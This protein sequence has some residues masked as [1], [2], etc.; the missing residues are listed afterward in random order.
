MFHKK[1]YLIDCIKTALEK[2]YR[3]NQNEKTYLDLTIKTLEKYDD[4]YGE[5]IILPLNRY[6]CNDIVR[7]ICDFI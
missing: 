5:K 7:Y 6:F 1:I 2:E 3:L 4:H